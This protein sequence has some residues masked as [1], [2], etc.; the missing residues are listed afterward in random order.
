MSAALKTADSLTPEALAFIK[1]G[2]P[3]PQAERPV[4]SSAPLGEEPECVAPSAEAN[5]S[6]TLKT[7]R[8][9][10]L[11]EEDDAPAAQVAGLVGLSF[12]VAS[13]IHVALMQAAFDR[14]MRRQRPFTQQEI[15][16]EALSLWLKKH[17]YSA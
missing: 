10:V 13:Q 9:K 16:S 4:V 5:S 17:G 12:R 14:K 15:V 7:R 6:E 2:T 3:K 8:P 11:E 1:A